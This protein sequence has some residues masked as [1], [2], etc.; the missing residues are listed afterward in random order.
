MAGADGRPDSTKLYLGT[1]YGMGFGTGTLGMR[2]EKAGVVDMIKSRNKLSG[3]TNPFAAQNA[4]GGGGAG[5]AGGW[6][7]IEVF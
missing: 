6:D 7:V 4:G 5:G 3:V 2:R 1:G